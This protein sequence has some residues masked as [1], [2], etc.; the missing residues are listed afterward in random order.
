MIGR[1]VLRIELQVRGYKRAWSGYFEIG[2]KLI[3]DNFAFRENLQSG[4]FGRL[5]CPV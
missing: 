4:A 3:W 1:N 2:K 5:D